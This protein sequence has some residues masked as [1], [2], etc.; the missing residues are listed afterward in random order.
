MS[1]LERVE[2]EELFVRGIGVGGRGRLGG[3]HDVLLSGTKELGDDDSGHIGSGEF[4][5]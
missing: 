5:A 2:R 4:N 1:E 3:V